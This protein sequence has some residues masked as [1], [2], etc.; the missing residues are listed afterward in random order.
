MWSSQ[1][2]RCCWGCLGASDVS[3]H[4]Q[5]LQIPWGWPRGLWYLQARGVMRQRCAR[6]CRWYCQRRGWLRRDGQKLHGV[7]GCHRLRRCAW[8]GLQKV[9]RGP[10][11]EYGSYFRRLARCCSTLAITGHH[12]PRVDVREELMWED[13]EL[14]MDHCGGQNLHLNS[15]RHPRVPWVLSVVPHHRGAVSCA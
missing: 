13:H 14:R 15:P 7:I 6:S 8:N 5:C 3:L 1:A 12:I 11:S 9:S 2:W 4:L 10:L